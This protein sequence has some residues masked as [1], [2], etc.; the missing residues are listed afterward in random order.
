MAPFRRPGLA[1]DDDEGEIRP[2]FFRPPRNTVSKPFHVAKANPI[3]MIGDDEESVVSSLSTLS[4]LESLYVESS[5]KFH[6]HNPRDQYLLCQRLPGQ[7]GSGGLLGDESEESEER[8]SSGLLNGFVGGQNDDDDD[9]WD[10]IVFAATNRPNNGPAKPRKPRSVP[11]PRAVVDP[12]EQERLDFNRAV[13]ESIKQQEE[14]EKRRYS[15]IER[16]QSEK[17]SSKTSSKKSSSSDSK[18]N[19]KSKKAKKTKEGEKKDEK[20]RAKK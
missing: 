14:D 6:T 11:S 5:A 15:L 2:E 16:Q 10:D 7:R 4:D 8:G 3:T 19:K 13:L 9:D 20:R 1:E 18:K 12:E 17:Q